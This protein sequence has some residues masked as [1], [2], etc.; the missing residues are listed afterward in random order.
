M[1]LRFARFIYQVVHSSAPP[2]T[3]DKELPS[4][5]SDSFEDLFDGDE[6][7][8]GVLPEARPVG[9]DESASLMTTPVI[10]EPPVKTSRLQRLSRLQPTSS[11]Q[12][13]DQVAIQDG[14]GSGVGDEEQLEENTEELL[15]K[16]KGTF[17]F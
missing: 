10:A 12:T 5:Y 9:A 3:E 7:Q 17:W 1:F 15:G 11:G 8:A 2:S 16:R 6:D 14:S 13:G 4:H